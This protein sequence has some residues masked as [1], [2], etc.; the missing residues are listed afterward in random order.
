MSQN[1]EILSES[2]NVVDLKLRPYIT[3][4]NFDF[5]TL[6]N[7]FDNKINLDNL[8]SKS[9]YIL[10]PSR[11]IYK[12][13]NNPIFQ[14]SQDYYN[15]LFSDNFKKIY[16]SH[17]LDFILNYESAEETFTVFDFPTIRL[18]EKKYFKK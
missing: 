4:V 7:S 6:D 15:N 17:N 10:I 18:Y 8:L 11:R 16:Q 14:Y 13:Q 3:V 2:G 12:N 5:Y 1:S 9:D